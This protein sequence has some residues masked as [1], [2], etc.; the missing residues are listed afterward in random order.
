MDTKT[1]IS[2]MPETPG[3][4]LMHDAD[5][6]I[7][8]VG[9]SKKLRAR[10]SSY[11]VAGADLSPAKRSMVKQVQDIEYIETGSEIEAL[12]LETN[13]IKLHTPKYNIL[14]KDDKN[15]S[16]IHLTG[17]PVPELRRVR[18]RPTSGTCFG[19]YA[20]DTDI[21]EALT[22]LRRIFRIRA[23]RVEFLKK[24]NGEL[25]I[26]H[27]AGRSIPC[28]DH[29][30]GLCPAPCLLTSETL[31]EHAEHVK[32]FVTYMRGRRGDIISELTDR[33][34]QAAQN[35]EYEEAG[36]IKRQIDTLKRLGVRQ[37]A[38]DAI[39]GDHRIIFYLEKYEKIYVG[40]TEVADG[41]IRGVRTTEIVPR[42]GETRSE[43]VSLVIMEGLL[44]EDDRPLQSI[45][46]DHPIDDADTLAYLHDRGIEVSVSATGVRR[47][48]LEFTERQVVEAAYRRR[49]ASLSDRTLTRAT[50]ANILSTLGYPVAKS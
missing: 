49:M 13:L 21:S 44:A 3:V 43:I 20:T 12:V 16:Y 26:G 1:F 41:E 17:D 25:A 34:R 9:K 8:Y 24:S 39:P 11:F 27:K 42:L 50:M 23:C 29:Y 28:M 2:R 31:A 40:V 47:E 30:I 46:L 36:K 38:R 10:V 33:M 15:L 18:S 32:A 7:I 14:M 5:G 35:L 48:L 4:Y 37:I 22:V 45:I 6:T 19:P